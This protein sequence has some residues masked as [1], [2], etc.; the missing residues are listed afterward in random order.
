MDCSPRVADE[1]WPLKTRWT[2]FL[3][4]PEQSTAG[5]AGSVLVLEAGSPTSRCFQGC[6]PS[7]TSREDAPL[8]PLRAASRPGAPWLWSHPCRPYLS[9]RGPLPVFV[10]VQVPLAG[11]TRVVWTWVRPE[12]S[13]DLMTYAEAHFPRPI[14]VPSPV[15]GAATSA[16]LSG[17]TAQPT[18]P[19]T[20]FA[21]FLQLT[22]RARAAA[23]SHSSR[24]FL[25]RH[26]AA[27]GALL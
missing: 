3:R 2:H 6:A 7:E 20:W 12:D 5:Q 15:P 23:F 19:V 14:T 18:I 10:C 25:G 13:S 21:L 4:L 17:D 22:R 26:R 16:L 8:L 1:L 24:A 9:P 27:P 11:R